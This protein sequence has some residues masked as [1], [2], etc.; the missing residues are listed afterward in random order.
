[1][2]EHAVLYLSRRD[3]ASLGLGMREIID[4]LERVFKASAARAMMPPKAW[5][6]PSADAFYSAMPCYVP[7]L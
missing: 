1:M 5:I 2:P 7:S 6:E 4:A 3:V